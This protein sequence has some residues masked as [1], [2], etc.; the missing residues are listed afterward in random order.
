ME[1]GTALDRYPLSAGLL[2]INWRRRMAGKNEVPDLD[3]KYVRLV[4]RR[5]DGLVEFE[6]SLADPTLYVEMLLPADAYEQ[7][8]RENKVIYLE[9]ERPA[10]EPDSDWEWRLHDAA[11]QRFR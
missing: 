11:Q 4:E 5:A 6:F 1:T 2:L 9:G 3:K 10:G 8:C 7:F